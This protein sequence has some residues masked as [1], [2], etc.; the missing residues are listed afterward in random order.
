MCVKQGLKRE[1]AIDFLLG[2]LSSISAGVSKLSTDVCAISEF[3]TRPK[4]TL[5]PLKM[6]KRLYKRNWRALENLWVKR[7]RRKLDSNMTFG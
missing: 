3:E 2:R 4:I 5:T 1:E 6:L 7:C